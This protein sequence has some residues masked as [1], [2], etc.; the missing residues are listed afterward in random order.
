[1]ERIYKL[2]SANKKF[3][4]ADMLTIQTDCLGIRSF[5]RQR[6]VYAIDHTASA[7]PRAKAAADLM[8]NWDGTMATTWLRP[9][10]LTTRAERWRSCC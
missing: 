4:A 2:L 3:T 1:M 8:R 5:L 9:R 6:F 10:S 7:S